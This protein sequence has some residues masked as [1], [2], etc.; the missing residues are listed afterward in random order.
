MTTM[1]KEYIDIAPR[2]RRSVNLEADFGKKET[3]D[4]YVV[5]PLACDLARRV[6]AG[7]SN[8]DGTRAWSIVGPYGTGKSSFLTYV[9]ALLAEG[10][11]E[12]L[13]LTETFWPEAKGEFESMLNEAGPL[14]PVLVTGQQV[15]AAAAILSAAVRAA[16]D[17]WAGPG[18]NPNIID[19]LQSL[20]DQ[21]AAG[22][23]V[24]DS[25][26]VD[27]LIELSDTVVQSSHD[28]N[29]I[30]LVIDE[31]GKFL[32]YAANRG[33]AGDIYLFQLLAEASARSEE[34]PFVLITTLHQGLDAYAE[35]LPR[36]KQVEWS[37]VSG[38]F[39][40]VPFLETPR[41]LTKLVNGAVVRSEFEAEPPVFAIIRDLSLKICTDNDRLAEFDGEDLNGCAPLHPITSLCLGPLFRSRL[42]QNERSLFAF[43]TSREPHGFQSYLGDSP[44]FEA[45]P[46]DLADLYDY[47]VANTGVRIVANSGDRTWAAAQ[48]AISRLPGD[49]PAIDTILIKHIA[50]LSLVGVHVALRADEDTLTLSTG[51]DRDAVQAGLDRLSEQS[52]IVFRQFKQAYHVWD[53]S[54]L[55]ISELLEERRRK[56]VAA[57]GLARKLQ[58]EFPPY[59][60]VAT[61]HYH[62]SGTLRHLLAKYVGVPATGNAWPQ[63]KA[64]DG[65]LLFIVPDRLEELEDAQKLVESQLQW[66][67]DRDR[68]LVIAL[69]R[70]PKQLLAR[71]IDYFAA[72]DAL[73]NTP[74]LSGDPVGRRE[75]TDRKL[76][77]SDRLVDALTTA[78][79]SS[80]ERLVWYWKGETIEGERRV[81]ACA[82]AIFDE[83][84]DQAPQIHNEL[85]N[86][87]SV[88]SFTSGA[89]RELMEL[90]IDHGDEHRLGIEG[91]PAELS[92]YRSI[93]ERE[94]IHEETDDG[95]SFNEPTPDSS[96]FPTWE[97]LDRLFEES[98]GKRFDVL[99]LM[100]ELAK[101]PLGIREGVAPLLILAFFIT[102]QDRLFLY[103]DNSF[104]PAPGADLAARLL[105]R[106]STFELQQSSE[107]GETG[108]VVRAVANSVGFDGKPTVLN[109]VR[110][111]VRLVARLSK[112]AERTQNLS[113]QARHVRNAVRSSRDPVRLL[114]EDLPKALGFVPEEIR[115]ETSATE[116]FAEMLADALR[117]L[118]ALDSQLLDTI[119]E[120]LRR[121]FGGAE[122]LSFYDYLSERATALDD[123]PYVP[124]RIRNFIA[125]A[126]NASGSAEERHGFLQD[127][128]TAVLG[129]PPNIWSDEDVRQF[130][131]RS[132]EASRDFLAAEQLTGPVNG[133]TNG[134]QQVIRV[135]VLDDDGNEHHGISTSGTGT[136]RLTAFQEDLTRL[137]QEHGLE[138]RDMAFAVIASMMDVLNSDSRNG[139]TA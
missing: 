97:F 107:F 104:L 58:K 4:G 123:Q 39:E 124:T 80:A 82:S 17:F 87:D 11:E 85:I 2:F 57:G 16:E 116:S 30:C 74:E 109:V 13:G 19:R 6:L 90:M 103:E 60:V 102:R 8:T 99:T 122:D 53:G 52:A 126:M 138:D 31:M 132:L 15:H 127:A 34:A 9:G 24:P 88:S 83:A 38:R 114:F 117:E 130:E 43:L 51:S 63:G 1:L 75:L 42:G 22:T 137:A 120:K 56:V 69:P 113:D 67:G 111:I 27:S 20:V 59:P 139:R 129:K 45:K 76:A 78:F 33:D 44:A 92:L 133:Q 91:F 23:L 121:F 108:K 55:N 73:K 84:Y 125:V 3:L 41:Y 61:R 40:T 89:R 136:N 5:S 135:S 66:I 119:D 79:T 54:D 68:P 95:W 94:G 35:G 32:E 134:I 105:K 47:L 70:H 12:A 72:V 115:E 65:D 96:L 29:G 18:K 71:V 77:A 62:Q 46:Y 93:F 106:P 14:L 49:A 48:Q 100:R 112:Y 101:P 110:A 81:S 98:P 64:G 28:G 131:F 36:A 118:Q 7:A 25:E 128:A 21:F 50:I 37:K 10:S 26:V 86:R